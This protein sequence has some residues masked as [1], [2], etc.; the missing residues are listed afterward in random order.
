MDTSHL[1]QQQLIRH[2]HIVTDMVMKPIA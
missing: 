1:S 2:E